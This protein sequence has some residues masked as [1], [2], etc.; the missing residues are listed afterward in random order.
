MSNKYVS[1]DGTFKR[2]KRF[3]IK[4]KGENF[5]NLNADT[6][7][8][9]ESY[10][11]C[12]CFKIQKVL[13]STSKF[14]KARLKC[15]TTVYSHWSIN[16]FHSSQNTYFQVHFYFAQ[17]QL[18]FLPNYLPCLHRNMFADQCPISVFIRVPVSVIGHPN[19]T[20]IFEFPCRIRNP[21]SLFLLLYSF[22]HPLLVI[23]PRVSFMISADGA[24][25]GPTG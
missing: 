10:P 7:I 23:S 25:S 13:S 9:D 22:W 11:T 4:R 16:C 19:S 20:A 8:D 14:L 12:C 17:I 3:D 15:C 5:K 6:W 18:F 24:L 1:Q 21:S 2:K